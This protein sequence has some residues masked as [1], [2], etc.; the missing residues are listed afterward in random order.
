MP[1]QIMSFELPEIVSLPYVIIQTL[2]A[3]GNMGDTSMSLP[4]D[5]SVMTG[6]VENT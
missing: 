3:E 5:I 1:L 6:I 2:D 4:I